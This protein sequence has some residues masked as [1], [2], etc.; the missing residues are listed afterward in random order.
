MK[1][2]TVLNIPD[3]HFPNHDQRALDVVLA[4]VKKKKPTKIMLL[5]DL[6]DGEQLSSYQ[7]VLDTGAIQNELD[8]SKEF[9][10]ELRK[11]AGKNTEILLKGGNH[12]NRVKRFLTSKAAELLGLNALKMENLFSLTDKDINIKWI[13]YEK[14]YTEGDVIWTH[15]WHVRPKSG[16]SAHAGLE[17]SGRFNGVSGHTHRL[18]KVLRTDY[19]GTPKYWIESGFL[20][21][22]NPEDWKYMDDRN[23]DWQQGFSFTHMFYNDND[24]FQF[25]DTDIISI[26]NGKAVYCGELIG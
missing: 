8:Q 1:Q 14:R 2:K 3:I 17:H 24:E 21:S 9:L 25:S 15:G 12:D 18:A 20:G 22:L 23:A 6:I 7:K 11:A 4:F 16:Y 26:K 19:G 5:G 13:P 10:K